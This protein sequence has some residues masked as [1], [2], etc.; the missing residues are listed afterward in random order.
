M[1]KSTYRLQRVT[2]LLLYGQLIGELQY[3]LVLADMHGAAL[4]LMGASAVLQRQTFAEFEAIG[5]AETL[6]KLSL[7]TIHANEKAIC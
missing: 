2:P 7:V 6:L 1:G 4:Q 5:Y 3:W